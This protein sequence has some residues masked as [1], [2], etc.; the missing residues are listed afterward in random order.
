VPVRIA[1]VVLAAGGSRRMGRPKQLLEIRGRPLLEQVVA[2]ACASRL[3][4]VV[5]VLGADATRLRERVRWGRARTLVNPD[6][7]AG[8][9]TSLRAA[10]AGLTAEVAAAMIILGDLPW[11]R[12]ESVDR[13]IEAWEVAGRPVTAS[14][15]AGVLQPPV[16]VTRAL[17]PAIGELRGDVG[18][19]AVIRS[20]PELVT[21]VD[22]T[23]ATAAVDVD[24][25]DDWRR[26]S[27]SE[28]GPAR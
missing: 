11:L 26:A 27:P 28:G 24:T 9:S 21:A 13:L 15:I 4:E 1:G 3:D 25:P 19:R 18:L 10:I 17:W 7:D 16:L 22:V 23:V 5:V 12:P 20:R 2:A 8:M 14:R 6:A